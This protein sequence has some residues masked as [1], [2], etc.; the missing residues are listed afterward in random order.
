MNH[1]P[2][3]TEAVLYDVLMTD[4]TAHELDLLERFARRYVLPP[5]RGGGGPAARRAVAGFRAGGE[6]AARGARAGG[7]G[8]ARGARAATSAARCDSRPWRGPGVPPWAN[9]WLEPACG[10]GRL[11][12]LA[13]A[14]GRRIA[15]FDASE[16]M[17]DYTRAALRRRGLARR[18]RVFLADMTDFLGL[19]RPGSVDFAFNL[20]NSIRHLGSDRAMLDHFAQMA[21]AVR[22]GGVYIVGL[23]LTDYVNE[24]PDEDLWQGARG[25]LQVKHLVNYLPPE[26]GPRARAE[27]VISHL[28]VR[29]PSGV[30]HLDAV[31]DLRCYDE[32]QWLRLLARSPWERVAVLDIKGRP[33]AGKKLPYQHEVLRRRG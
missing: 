3:Y 23:S 2:L 5:G 16:A 9:R 10:T 6:S 17:V 21:R 25:R 13:A 12:R 18:G 1:N 14:R 24:R 20:V 15:G 31:Y 4:G 19:V 30:A 8:E 29:R 28:T 11:L 22:P 33:A 32:P 26:P 7:E 27:R